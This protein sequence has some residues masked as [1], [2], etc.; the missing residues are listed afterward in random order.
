MDKVQTNV[1][2]YIHEQMYI[3]QDF[4]ILCSLPSSLCT[5]KFVNIT[6]IHSNLRSLM[7]MMHFLSTTSAK[8]GSESG[9]PRSETFF[10]SCHKPWDLGL[11][12]RWVREFIVSIQ[13]EVVIR[14]RQ[15][16]SNNEWDG[17]DATENLNGK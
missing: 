8:N 9:F 3:H 15:T 1:Q 17:D 16:E 10:S 12:H 2:V 14:L 13:L 11:F 5:S 4:E 7:T 6:Q